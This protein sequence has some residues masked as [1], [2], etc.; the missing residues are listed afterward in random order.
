M[1][2]VRYTPKLGESLFQYVFAR[3]LAERFGY[4][5]MA[6]P[7]AGFP[8]TRDVVDGV[9]VLAPTIYWT[10]Q[11]LEAS[12]TRRALPDAT[13]H[14][15]PDAKVVVHGAFQRFEYYEQYADE[16][17]HRYLRGRRE[18]VPR[19]PDDLVV[20]IHPEPDWKLDLKL[21]GE[22][23]MDQDT[24]SEQSLSKAEVKT[25]VEV[26][27][28]N[29]V[30]ILGS[31][32]DTVWIEEMGAEAVL[33]TPAQHFDWIRSFRQIAI[34]QSATQWWAAYL[35]HA[36]A[37]YFPPLNRG[38]WGKPDRRIDPTEPGFHGIDLRVDDPRY[39]YGWNE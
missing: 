26:S 9:R 38:T 29:Q 37:I 10:G 35:S 21:D 6:P 33:G 20:C 1:I 13:L 27:G 28:A 23:V 32:A 24:A 31:A 14:S 17:K 8:G 30:F 3:I 34:S 19:S 4:A 18:V 12:T 16:I 11:S 39:V 25:L 22:Q 15:P 7:I 2:E 5:L 36:S